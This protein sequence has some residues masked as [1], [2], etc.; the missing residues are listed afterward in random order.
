VD[1][2]IEPYVSL[3]LDLRNSLREEKQWAQ[4]DQIRDGLQDTG[5]IIEDHAEGSSW[6]RNSE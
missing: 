5:I 2:V 4:A 1:G 6:R 3:L